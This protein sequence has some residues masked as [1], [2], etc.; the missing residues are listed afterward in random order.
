MA[1]EQTALDETHA[2]PLVSCD[3]CGFAWYGRTAAHG[4]SVIG[5]CSRC[6]G[7]LRFHGAAEAPESGEDARAELQPWQVL[8]TPTSWAG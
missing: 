5:H 7:S 6:D 4:L 3:D 2:Q 1:T 8:G